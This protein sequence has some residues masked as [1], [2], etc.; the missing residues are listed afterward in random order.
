MK[1]ILC[2]IVQEEPLINEIRIEYVL[3]WSMKFVNLTDGISV[4]TIHGWGWSVVHQ[5]LH[6]HSRLL[7]ARAVHPQRAPA[8]LVTV[9][10]VDCSA[11]L[12]NKKQN[13][14]IICSYCLSFLSIEIQY[15]IFSSDNYNNKNHESNWYDSYIEK[16][17]ILT[18]LLIKNTTHYLL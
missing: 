2:V 4:G 5:V 9:Q 13:L 18:W 12:K 11:S 6:F 3:F 15:N 7:R 17:L 8:D 1:S 16:D 10:V 14:L